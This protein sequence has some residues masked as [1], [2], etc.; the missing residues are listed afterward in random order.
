MTLV[1]AM[2]FWGKTPKTQATKAEVDKWRL[3]QTR[4]LL[5]RKG[6]NQENGKST[7]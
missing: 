3:H 7:H 4:K 5:H 1:W 2:N 6:N